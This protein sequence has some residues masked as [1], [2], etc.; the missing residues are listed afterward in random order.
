MYCTYIENTVILCSW[1][2]EDD[3]DGDGDG[4]GDGKKRGEVMM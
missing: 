2:V 1:D 3:K 4:D